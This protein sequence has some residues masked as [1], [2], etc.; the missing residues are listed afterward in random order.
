MTQTKIDNNNR[1]NITIGEQSGSHS[2]SPAII[3]DI[4]R[5]LEKELTPEIDSLTEEMNRM[6]EDIWN[7]F[8]N[9]KNDKLEKLLKGDI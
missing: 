4:D 1:L 8:N 2:S 7:V 6:H 9:V 3:F 5:I